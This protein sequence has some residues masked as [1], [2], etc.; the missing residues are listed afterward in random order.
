MTAELPPAVAHL[1]RL[2]RFA[3]ATEL[4]E[5]HT[6]ASGELRLYSEAGEELPGIDA[7]ELDERD[8]AFALAAEIVPL[9]GRE[10]QSRLRDLDREEQQL[11]K[12][13]LDRPRSANPLPGESPEQD[14]HDAD[15]EDGDQVVDAVEDAKERSALPSTRAE[16]VEALREVELE[17]GDSADEPE[18]AARFASIRNIRQVLFRDSIRLAITALQG[19]LGLLDRNMAL[20]AACG[21]IDVAL[22]RFDPARG[23]Q[24]STYAVHWIRHRL[25]RQ[26]DQDSIPLRVPVHALENARRYL[27]EERKQWCESG[28]RPGPAAVSK[29]LDIE[30]SNVI[31]VL[32]MLPPVLPGFFASPTANAGALAEAVLDPS[33][34]SLWHGGVPSAWVT[35]TFAVIEEAVST[36]TRGSQEK[37]KRAEDVLRRRLAVARPSPEPLRAVGVLHKISRERVRQIQNQAVSSIQRR[38]EGAASTLDARPWTWKLR[39]HD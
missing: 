4:E 13:W 15:G 21:G 20:L 22:D 33:L 12:L 3:W 17:I 11:L 36:A 9:D 38:L 23:T 2:R 32:E 6:V 19:R 1:F 7:L 10:R 35:R 14:G 31:R 5:G 25:G 30:E 37:V 34:P 16:R 24:F 39:K 8:Q 18:I 29:G 26:R 27:V 28:T